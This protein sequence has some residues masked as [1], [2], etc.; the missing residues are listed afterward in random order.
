MELPAN[1]LERFK[2][3]AP[4]EHAPRS[5]R[6]LLLDEFMGRLN[7]DQVRDGYEE[8]TPS[9]LAKVLKDAGYAEGSWHG[10]YKSCERAR[11]FGALF[12]HL[13]KPKKV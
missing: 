5:S 2:P 8:Y 11:S 4:K 1:Y 6:D 3:A 7:P 10:L 12:K 9:Y 13:T